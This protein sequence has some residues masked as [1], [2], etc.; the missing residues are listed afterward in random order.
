MS[1]LPA[2]ANESNNELIF[3]PFSGRFPV[4]FNGRAGCE[5]HSYARRGF[6]LIELLVVIAIIAV[7]AAILF[8]TFLTVQGKAREATCVS[9]LRQAGLA[10]GMYAQ[11]YDGIY[12]FAI[13]PADKYTPYIWNS[14]PEFKALIP[15][16]PLINDVLQPYI[17]SKEM[18]RCPSDTGFDVEDFTGD[19]IDPNG[20]PKNATPTSFLKFGTSYYYRTEIAIRQA[21]EATFQNPS[22]LN[23]LFDGAGK[24]HGSFLPFSQRYVTL[25]G[26]NHVKNITRARK[27]IIGED[28]SIF[29]TTDS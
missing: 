27:V 25:F 24:W 5:A 19:L 18:F 22:E 2:P 16:L 13:D 17:K 21:G 29:C 6:T 23:V 20:K 8:P 7:L 10:I 1:E 26:D 9:N 11:D 15:Q 4:N 12:P 14:F 28:E 3:H